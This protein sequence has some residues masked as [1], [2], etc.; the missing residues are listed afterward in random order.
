[1]R[2]HLSDQSARQ[3]RIEIRPG[4]RADVE[5]HTREKAAL[6]YLT[7]P[8]CRSHAAPREP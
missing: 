8:Q 4:M 3:Q 2:P 5:L 7:K 1:M 6:Q